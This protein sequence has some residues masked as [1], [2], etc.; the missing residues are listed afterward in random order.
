M[1]PADC[2]LEKVAFDG[3]LMQCAMFG[4]V[5]AAERMQAMPKW[6]LER[7]RCDTRHLNDA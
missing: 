3:S 7:Y 5:V 1:A 6:H 4:Q 2:H